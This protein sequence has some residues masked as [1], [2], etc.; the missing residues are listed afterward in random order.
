MSIDQSTDAAPADSTVN[1]ETEDG[2]REAMSGYDARTIFDPSDSAT[3]EA[4][5]RAPATDDSTEDA[6]AGADDDG[7][8]KAANR[9]DKD[10]A[11]RGKTWDEINREKEALAQERQRIQ[12]EKDQIARD[13]ATVE[14]GAKKALSSAEDYEKFAKDWDAEG[15]E[16]L[17]RQAREK[18]VEL[19]T[20]AFKIQQDHELKRLVTENPDLR[21][22]ESELTRTVDGLLKARPHLLK[23]PAGIRDAVEFA[24]AKGAE[25]RLAQV[26]KELAETK[27]RLADTQK[28]LQP[29]TGGRP[30]RP[31]TPKEFSRMSTSD[32]ETEL[33]RMLREADNA[34][35]SLFTDR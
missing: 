4:G 15:R 13:A 16:D 10:E 3:P 1:L 22:P 19:R 5:T 24:K 9:T 34:G 17:A 18:A 6:D 31:L 30:G 12:A 14:D 7:G 20:Q 11:R 25:K 8:T 26:E 21:N 28:K 2:L 33:R 29:A 27:Q 32:R 23:S 35:V